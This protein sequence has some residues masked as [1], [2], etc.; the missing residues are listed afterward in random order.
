MRHPFRSVESVVKNSVVPK[1]FGNFVPNFRE[2]MA[3]GKHPNAKTKNT[4]ENNYET[5]EHTNP[6]FN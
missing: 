3:N 5:Y 6:N 4:K 1:F 2:Q